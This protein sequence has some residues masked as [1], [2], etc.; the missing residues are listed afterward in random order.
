VHVLAMMDKLAATPGKANIFL[1]A[2]RALSAW[3]RP[4]DK[5]PHSYCEGV[6]AYPAAA[7]TSRGRPRRSLPLKSI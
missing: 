3:A 4:R 1:G 7:V 2:I 5:I 6:K